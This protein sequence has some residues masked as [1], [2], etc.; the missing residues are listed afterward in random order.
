MF[1]AAIGS[2]INDIW[3]AVPVAHILPVVVIVIT[4]PVLDSVLNSL[5]R[6]FLQILCGSVLPVQGIC[7]RSSPLFS[8][9]GIKWDNP[10]LWHETDSQKKIAKVFQVPATRPPQRFCHP[11]RSIHLLY[12][13][14]PRMLAWYQ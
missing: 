3:I 14:I 7:Y 13:Y 2:T 10:G 6:A 12:P 9:G 8:F 4:A 11:S 1:V 5:G